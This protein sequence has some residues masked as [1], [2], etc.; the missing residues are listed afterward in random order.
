[1]AQKPLPHP[2]FG[3]HGGIADQD[4]FDGAA[5]DDL[6]RLHAFGWERCGFGF[7]VS[8]EFGRG[9]AH[10]D[11]DDAAKDVGPLPV[12]MSLVVDGFSVVVFLVMARVLPSFSPILSR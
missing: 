4:N 12:E 3:V 2:A 1:M 8:C 9:F 6:H 10:V 5:F 11:S 7:D